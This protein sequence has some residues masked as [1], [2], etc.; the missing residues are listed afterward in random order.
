MSVN[1]QIAKD[2]NV[3]ALMLQTQYRGSAT[4]SAMVVDYLQRSEEAWVGEADGKIACLWG[5]IPPTMM[6]TRGY[7]WLLVT[8]EVAEHKFLF[9]RHSQL[10]VEEM[11]KKYSALYGYTKVG[12]W[13]SKRWLEWLGAR[14][15]PR[16]GDAIP[17]EIE[18]RL[19]QTQ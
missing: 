11:L 8:D 19:W 13:R 17:F 7:L 10:V 1:I 14:F 9:V 6:S 15:Q 4:A 18:G 12:E 16:E 5:V 2:L 3:P